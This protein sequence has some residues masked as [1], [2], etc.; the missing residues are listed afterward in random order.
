MSFQVTPAATRFASVQIG[1]RGR[2]PSPLIYQWIDFCWQP[3]RAFPF[4]QE[5]IPGSPP[6]ALGHISNSKHQGII[7]ANPG[8]EVNLVSRVLSPEVLVRCEFLEPLPE[9]ALMDYQWLV[10]QMRRPPRS[11]MSGSLQRLLS[12]IKSFSSDSLKR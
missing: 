2:G 6:S 3:A 11:W 9:K 5:I 12:K 7:R 1:G 8:K 10:A 4:K